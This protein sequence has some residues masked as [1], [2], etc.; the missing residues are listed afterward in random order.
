[1]SLRIDKV[2]LEIIINNDEAR[3]RLRALDTDIKTLSKELARLPEGTEEFIAKSAQLKSV[4]AE[5]EKLKREIG[6]TGM[7]LKELQNHQRELNMVMLHMDPRIPEYKIL[8]RELRETTTRV[9]E[10]R[11]G[12][13]QMPTTMQQL[14]DSFNRYQSVLM[15]AGV[16]LMGIIYTFNTFIQGGAELSDSLA[17]IQKTTDMTAQEVR[18]LN[19]ELG[20][21][22]TRTSRKELRDMAIVAG[23]LGIAKKDIYDFVQS[24]DVLNVAL[25]DEITGGAGEVAKVMGTLRNVLTDMKSTNVSQDM[26]RIGDA[27][28]EL[29]KA[30]FA[31]APVIADFANRIGGIGIPLGLTSDEILGLSATLQELNINTERGGTAVGRIL[32]KMARNTG[33]FAKV[34]GIPIKEFT[35][36][37]N[38]DLMGA[39][40]KV[41]EGTKRGG[42]NA[43]VLAGIIKELEVQ[44]AGASEV[45]A[46]LGGNVAMLNEK[47]DLAGKTLQSSTSSTDEFNIKNQTMGAI[48]DKLVKSL[49][50]LIMLPSLQE[51]FK[52]MIMTTVSLVAW[53]KEL[54]QTIEKY[55]VA[56]TLLGAAIGIWI[57]SVTRGIQVQIWNNLVTK[58]GWLL[59]SADLALSKLRTAWERLYTFAK[60]E[61]TIATKA[62]TASQWLWNA[63]L[64]AN[65]IGLLIGLFA[66][67]VAAIKAYDKYNA[68]SVAIEE[69]KSDA[70]IKVSVLTS[71]AKTHTDSYAA[72]IR[73][74]NN[75]SRDKKISL[76]A[77]IDLMLENNKAELESLKL[78]R[79]L[80]FAE[81]LKLTLWQKLGYAIGG[82]NGKAAEDIVDNANLAVKDLDETI[83][84]Y[85]QSV[86]VA[87]DQKKTL[88]DV[89]N[90]EAQGDAIGISTLEEMDAKMSKYQIALRN[91]TKGGEDYLR[92]QQKIKDL[93]KL[94]NV[95]TPDSKPD[96]SEEKALK[97][98][99]KLLEEY[100]RLMLELQAFEVKQLEERMNMYSKEVYAVERK[101]DTE[102]EKAKKFLAENEKLSPK[103]KRTVQQG[104]DVLEVQ[105]GQAVK[106]EL[107]KQET[108]F[109]TDVIAIRNK[110]KAT[111][112]IGY[113]KELQEIENTYNKNIEAVTGQSDAITKYYDDEIAKAYGNALL[114]IDLENQKQNHITNAILTTAEYE[115]LKAEEVAALKEKKARDLED[116]IQKI[117][118]GR[119]AYNLSQEQREIAEIDSK[120]ARLLLLAE[121]NEE[122]K[123]RIE[124]MYADEIADY[125]AN[126]SAETQRKINAFL[127]DQAQLL[128]N[129]VFEIV[130][131]NNRSELDSRLAALSSQKERELSSKSLTE[132]QKAEI[133]AKYKR[134]EAAV[135]TK[136]WK[137]EQKA[138]LVQAVINGALA[139]TMI[140]ATTPK[141]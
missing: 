48:V 80:I 58:E 107:L 62:A 68:E 82:L 108:V 37:V 120:Y 138:A 139:I 109:T 84:A 9:N 64:A 127:V 91:L 43:T 86:S 11:N 54:P 21:I 32:Q 76:R 93:N 52:G 140:L 70:L 22:D 65:P 87:I 18:N 38:T 59:S 110:L 113:E 89:L 61:G 66:L 92:V 103:Q 121:G 137:D 14:G 16:A 63:A 5:Y 35:D 53:F 131:N 101:Y 17:D 74:L 79:Q 31:T 130:N 20:K 7:S 4:E 50:G 71:T 117:Q 119:T 46:K 98:R 33:D 75:L 94:R 100:Q 44:G 81:S 13:R 83:K 1:M 15:A 88:D 25:G 90:A 3:K 56:L 28:N 47:M 77:E 41:M 96:K 39:F 30:G 12:A 8:Q 112:L 55:K 126:K 116:E 141:F 49:Y 95:E 123:M 36:M 132:A 34:A 73:A 26:M 67:G 40:I 29:G 134:K 42:I 57:A 125:K 72:S 124:K 115:K 78:K 19:S 128:S 136:A 104:I 51:L 2:Q 97:D 60:S 45:F 133:E 10:L 23:Q 111:Q 85:E 6:I 118:E 99:N 106:D 69:Q 24:V 27:I 129:T 102:I 114:I 122:A 135:K 105:K